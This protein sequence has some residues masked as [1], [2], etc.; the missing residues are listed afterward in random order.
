MSNVYCTGTVPVVQT[1]LNWYPVDAMTISNPCKTAAR[2]DLLSS[3]NISALLIN[4][5]LFFWGKKGAF[6]PIQFLHRRLVAILA[7]QL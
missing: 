1:V 5:R 3:T 7:D 4:T 6:R 2:P